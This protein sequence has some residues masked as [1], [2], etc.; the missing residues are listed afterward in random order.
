MG[1]VMV[2]S[3]ML[4]LIGLSDRIIVFYAGEVF[5]AFSAEAATEERIMAA[6]SG[7]RGGEGN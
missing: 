7:T 4:E 2:T 3:D 1:V 6:S 5:D